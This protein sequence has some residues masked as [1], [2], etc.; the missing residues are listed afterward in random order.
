MERLV[1]IALLLFAILS[2]AFFYKIVEI[3]KYSAEEIVLELLK[4][5]AE[6]KNIS[7]E[8]LRV[9]KE[10]IDGNS[11]WKVLVS[12]V[13][14]PVSNCPVE[15]WRY[16]VV[17]GGS[18]D[19]KEN[20]ILRECGVTIRYPIDKPEEAITITFQDDYIRKNYATAKVLISYLDPILVAAKKNKDFLEEKC[21]KIKKEGWYVYWRFPEKAILFVVSRNGEILHR[22]EL[23][24]I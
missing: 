11:A 14:N 8:I 9:W 23:G 6:E 22:E 5:E 3:Q 18:V 15:V 19:Y 16:Y 12:L 1:I 2:L 24:K 10:K 7:Y 17:F 4:K 13:Y 20:R 21:I